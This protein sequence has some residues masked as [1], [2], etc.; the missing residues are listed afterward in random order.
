MG[1]THVFQVLQHANVVLPIGTVPCATLRTTLSVFDAQRLYCQPHKKGLQAFLCRCIR[2]QSHAAAQSMSM[3]PTAN[4]CFQ[5]KLFLDK[6][7]DAWAPTSY[8]SRL[9]WLLCLQTSPL[10]RQPQCRQSSSQQTWP[11]D[12]L[13][14]CKPSRGFW[15]MLQQASLHSIGQATPIA[16]LVAAKHVCEAL[17]AASAKCMVENRWCILLWKPNDADAS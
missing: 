13:Q 4:I 12:M 8:A 6:H 11:S 5:V 1:D 3:W 2:S 9:A 14:G 7:V 10:R 17:V 15:C 16:L